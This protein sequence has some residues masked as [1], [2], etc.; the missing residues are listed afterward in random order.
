MNDVRKSG[1]RKVYPKMVINHMMT[2]DDLIEKMR[3]Y[4]RTF[5]S[6]TIKAVIEDV[7]DMMSELMSMGYSVKLDGIGN[8]SPSLGFE[9]KK[10]NE[11]E[12][13]DDKM[14]YRKVCVKDINYKADPHF[15]KATKKKTSLTRVMSE[16][17]TVAKSHYTLKQRIQRALD[18]IKKNGY[19]SLSEY[20]S[21]NMMSRSAASK[22]LKRITA[23]EASPITYRGD[24]SHKVWVARKE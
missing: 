10:T 21:L 17:K 4:N 8:F 20:A 2:T 7:A 3:L 24:G 12:S 15:I 16:V 23:D 9:D 6:S 19:I 18:L 11:M 14:L 1:E 5:S 13:D 22:E